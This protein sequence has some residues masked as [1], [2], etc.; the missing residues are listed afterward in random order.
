[1]GVL[2]VNPGRVAPRQPVGTQQGHGMRWLLDTKE[3]CFCLLSDK[4]RLR[5][6]YETRPALGM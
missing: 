3:I 1:M 6:L 2:V 5:K 4:L